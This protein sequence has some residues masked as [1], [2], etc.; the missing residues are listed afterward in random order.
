M[1]VISR[2]T[3]PDVGSA[4]RLDYAGQ[5]GKANYAVHQGDAWIG[6]MMSEQASCRDLS[7]LDE[8]YTY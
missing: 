4:R 7:M 3:K 1:T 2:S 8:R 5:S 6:L